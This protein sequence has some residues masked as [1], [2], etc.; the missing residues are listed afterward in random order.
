MKT[1]P[2]TEQ[3]ILHAAMEE[4][5]DKGYALSKTTDI[6][7]AAGVTHAMFHYYFRT[8]ENLFNKV[9][10]EKVHFIAQSFISKFD[11]DLPFAEQLKQA[12]E[13]HFDLISSNRRLPV[14]IINEVFANEE[15]RE[16]CRNIF[17]PIIQNEMTRIQARI[18]REV[19][20]GNIRKISAIDLFMSLIS[21]NVFTFVMTPVVKILTNEDEAEYERFLLNRKR[22]NVE[23]ILSRISIRN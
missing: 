20:A 23:T 5:L 16:T 14:F 8:K 4:F 22:E 12:V 3:A 7:R 9:F 13:N 6:A 11:D 10:E 15:R 21:L 18:D 1:E 17:L 19:A 2:N